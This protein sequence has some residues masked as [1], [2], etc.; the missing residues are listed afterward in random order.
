M[1][2][3]F[4]ILLLLLFIPSLSAG[5]NLYEDQLNRGIRNSEPYSYLLINQSKT[6]R[7]NAKDILK[8]ALR[9]SPDLPAVY[10]EMAK[11]SFTFKTGGAFEAFDYIIQGIAAYKRNFWWSFMMI[12]SL[13]TSLV[14][15]FIVSLLIITLIRLPGDIPLLSH[16]LKEEKTRIM[17]LLVFI[18]AVFGPLY[19][20]GSLLIIISFYMRKRDK[21]LVYLYLLFLLT[22]P[23]VYKAFSAGLSVPSSGELRAVVQVNEA[24]GNRYALSVL[25]G[26]NDPGELFS[27]ALALKREGRYSEAIGIYNRLLTVNPD[28]RAYNNL[29]NCYVAIKDFEKA[30]ELYKKSIKIQ[31]LASSLYN[32]S[33]IYR[34]TLD[35]DKGD[36][37]FLA[38]QQLDAGAVSN[39]RSIFGR[40]PNRFVID[41]EL[42]YPA[43]R[44]Y[45]FK[46]IKNAP[47]GLSIIPPILI[48]LIV[49]VMII[50]FYILDRRLKNR[51]YRCNRCG[52][53]M[54]N[55]C[56]KHILWGHMCLQC[57]RSLVKLE[58][59]DA[60]ERI[61][62]ILAVYEYRK[63]KKDM[64]KLLSFILPG[65][66]Q[67]YAGYPLYGLLFL[68]PF[69]FLLF[70]PLANLVFRVEMAGFSHLWLNICAVFLMFMVYLIS[71]I[72]TRRRLAKGWL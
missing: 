69:L 35:F 13:F 22:S 59:L 37:Y 9:Y 5:K 29:A 15:S 51:A 71:N 6:D 1:K 45:A 50:L 2:K 28:P 19:F 60:R 56:E 14:L 66:G 43:I 12:L 23:W 34:E 7:D 67:I 26:S 72:I 54:C 25:Q 27:Y 68:W 8:E 18:F 38:A 30:E 55:K 49:I 52:K 58:E 39:F 36:E 57:Y 11:A 48:P 61:A 65:S 53:I 16:D 31:P 33:Q 32:L 42:P 44:E 3:V 40:N 64:I 41:E 4:L 17:L 62:R 46:K 24:K 21:I 63:K 70:I 10:F 47:S 20:L